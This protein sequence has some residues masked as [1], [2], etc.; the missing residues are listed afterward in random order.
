MP[1][2][3]KKK[4]VKKAVKRSSKA[5]PKSGIVTIAVISAL[6]IAVAVAAAV[7]VSKIKNS[8][9][10]SKNVVSSVSPATIKIT[11]TV[12]GKTSTMEVLPASAG[13]VQAAA[14]VTPVA[15]AAGNTLTNKS[16]ASIVADAI[17]TG[18]F[19]YLL[20]AAATKETIPKIDIAEAKFL[21]DSGKAVFIDARGPAEYAESH[22][23]G[24]ASVP[25]AATPEELDKLKDKLK[26]K[27]LVTYCHGVG[28]H[29]ADKTA[30]KLW[31]AG[32]RKVVIFFSG[33]PKWNEHKY[34]FEKK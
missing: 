19:N 29:L 5:A 20:N 9:L 33:W 8:A 22:I 4:A 32:Y 3:R 7:I 1:I 25:V 6:V 14:P 2:K 34:P 13:S 16:I 26:N 28:C 30:Y 23:R 17:K 12:T 10:T 27:V 11:D 18:S 21:F 31:D 24:A 15:Q